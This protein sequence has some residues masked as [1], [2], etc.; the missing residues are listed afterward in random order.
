MAANK[1]DQGCRHFGRQAGAKLWPWLLGLTRRQ[2]GF[3]RLLQTDFTLPGFPERVGD[4][5]A[6]LTD[7]ECAGPP[8]AVCAEFQSEPVFGMPD[9]L[10]VA[11]GLPRL[12]EEFPASA[13]GPVGHTGSLQPLR[14]CT[15]PAAGVR[16]R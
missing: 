2:V 9:R 1:H 15:R 12:T 7:L 14:C 5:V 13:T 4:L 3:L 10:M 16:D 11:L 8:W 6:A